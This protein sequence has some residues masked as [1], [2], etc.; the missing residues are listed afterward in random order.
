[1]AYG[2]RVNGSQI[3][4]WIKNL[5]YVCG[6]FF[7]W[8]MVSLRFSVGFISG[9]R[10]LLAIA[11]GVGAGVVWAGTKPVAGVR[12]RRHRLVEARRESACDSLL[13]RILSDFNYERREISLYLKGI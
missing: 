2:I 12:V 8:K 9:L 10:R 6:I 3:V 5:A 11:L 7:S 4:Y 1:M 13:F